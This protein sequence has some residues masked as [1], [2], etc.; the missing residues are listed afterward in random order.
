MDRTMLF[1]IQYLFTFSEAVRTLSH[2]L[3]E[4]SIKWLPIGK[5]S[6]NA[7]FF[8]ITV[9][10]TLILQHMHGI[11]Y[12]VFI[13]QTR[14]IHSKPWID[15]SGKVTCIGRQIL[16]QIL[17]WIIRVSVLLM[18]D[19]NFQNFIIV[20]TK[21]LNKNYIFARTSFNVAFNCII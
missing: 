12:S 7:D 18:N 14:K 11:F 15:N 21:T 17:C 4:S 8:N 1:R 10:I 2:N 3:I 19:Y 5:T 6:Q 9:W 20:S 16:C 13:Y